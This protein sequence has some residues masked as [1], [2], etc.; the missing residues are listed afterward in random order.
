MSTVPQTITPQQHGL[1]AEDLRLPRKSTIFTEKRTEIRHCTS[2]TVI[3]G[4]TLWSTNNRHEQWSLDDDHELGT[5]A[6][7]TGLAGGP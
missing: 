2:R 5:S 4:V 1:Y 7:R 3:Q 6:A